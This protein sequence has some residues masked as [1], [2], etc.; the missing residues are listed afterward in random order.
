ME[1][2]TYIR[3]IPG[4]PKEGILF[5]DIMPLLQDGKALHF[6]VEQLAAFGKA[7]RAELILGAEAR[8]FIL[9]AAVAYSLG[10][11][12][13]AARKPGKLP[14]KVSRCEYDLEYGADALE[15]H[16]DAVKPGQR[17]LIHD[18]LLATGGTA[19]AKIQLVEEAGGIVAGLAFIIELTG[20]H[21]R[22]RL[23]G[24]NVYSLIQYDV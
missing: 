17:V 4:F 13:A 18:D 21:G 5:H 3:H 15:M 14:W 16:A 11:G 2:D 20:L 24:Y 6:A 19:R 23:A 10:V 22:D 8:G 1:L 9:G 7:R 12:F